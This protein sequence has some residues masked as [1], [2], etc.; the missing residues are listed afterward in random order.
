ML[1][2]KLNNQNLQTINVIMEKFNC[3]KNMGFGII[4]ANICPII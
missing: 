1:F 3:G 2:R 4:Y